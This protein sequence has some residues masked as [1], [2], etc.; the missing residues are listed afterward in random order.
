MKKTVAPIRSALP[1]FNHHKTIATGT[2]TPP[3]PSPTKISL[4]AE[5]AQYATELKFTKDHMGSSPSISPEMSFIGSF[6][7]RSP[8]LKPSPPRAGSTAPIDD[9]EFELLSFARGAEAIIYEVAPPEIAGSDDVHLL[10]KVFRPEMSRSASPAGIELDTLGLLSEFKSGHHVAAKS[11]I[12]SNHHRV[13]FLMEKCENGNLHQFIL[14]MAGAR[15]AESTPAHISEMIPCLELDLVFQICLAVRDLHSLKRCHNDLKSENIFISNN[16]K[17]RLGDFSQSNETPAFSMLHASAPELFPDLFTD[18][19]PT[20]SKPPSVDGE[21]PHFSTDIFSIG[22][23]FV[24]LFSGYSLMEITEQFYS[25]SLDTMASAFQS[26]TDMQKK[27]GFFN[28][29]TLRRTVE[30]LREQSGAEPLIKLACPMLSSKPN[31]RPKLD[32]VLSAFSRL[33]IE[34]TRTIPD[35]QNRLNETAEWI[36]RNVG[37]GGVT[38]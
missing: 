21:I 6:G 13:G 20:L 8:K 18:E 17:V 15:S 34:A 1:I 9:I 36:H 3:I 10:A 11:V 16:R 23:I 27:H 33:L 12:V 2:R 4:P 32:A 14:K 5:A 22:H 29:F 38:K 35:F 19:F 37:E 7:A 25:N 26:Q 31:Q 24:E 28:Q 30:L